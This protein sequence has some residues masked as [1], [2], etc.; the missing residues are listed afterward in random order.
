MLPD[1]EGSRSRTQVCFFGLTDDV[2]YTVFDVAAQSVD[3]DVKVAA[4][5]GVVQRRRHDLAVD[6]AAVG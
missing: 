4:D 2:E 1:A 6:P 3:D 5:T